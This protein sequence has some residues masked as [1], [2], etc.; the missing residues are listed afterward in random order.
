ME[1]TTAQMEA[2]VPAKASTSTGLLAEAGELTAF[3]GRSLAAIGGTPRYASEVLRQAAMMIRGTWFLMLA[4]NMFLGMSLVNF[5]FFFLRSI[6]ASDFLGLT[7]GYVSIRQLAPTMFGYVFCAKVCCGMAAEIGAMKTNEEID[8]YDSTGVDPL[9]YVVGTRLV[10]VLLFMPL[11]TGL[12]L[13]GQIA[14]AYLDSVIILQG[15]APNVLMD[16]HWGVQTARD[17]LNTFLTICVLGVMCSLVAMFYGL[18]AT[19]GPAGV[20][21]ASARSIYVN[22]ILVHIIAGLMFVFFYGTDLHLPIGG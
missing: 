8:A 2:H 19:G 9:R 15:I 12:A 5:G 20:G 17:Q 21:T 6:G 10:A 14:G 7:S 3:G 16:V 18:R 4:M 13:I 11:A 22:L 1:S